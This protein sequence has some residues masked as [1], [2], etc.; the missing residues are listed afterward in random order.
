MF[1]Y[2]CNYKN[3]CL[4]FIKRANLCTIR[5]S[6]LEIHSV[7]AVCLFKETE[8]GHKPKKRVKSGEIEKKQTEREAESKRDGDRESKS[9]VLCV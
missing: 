9:G 7:V 8:E 5:T 6:K 1:L 3:K 4:A 2:S